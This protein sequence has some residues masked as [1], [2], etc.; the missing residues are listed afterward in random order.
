MELKSKQPPQPVGCVIPPT[1]VKEQNNQ[2]N[3]SVVQTVKK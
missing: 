3:I 2:Q 1:I